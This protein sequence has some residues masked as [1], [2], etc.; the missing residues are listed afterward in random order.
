MKLKFKKMYPDVQLPEFATEGSACF[1]IRAYCP[2]TWYDLSNADTAIIDTGLIPEVPKGYVLK[3]YSRS[4]YG[5]VHNIRLVNSVGII[6][7]DYRGEIKV[8]L[9]QDFTQPEAPSKRIVHGDRI[10]QGM[11]VKLVKTEIEEVEE[12]SETERG[13][14]GFGSTGSK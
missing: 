13:N 7:S 6:D 11:L 5:F 8:G 2:T 1:D 9:I 4:G 3:I 12:L 14:G 10:A